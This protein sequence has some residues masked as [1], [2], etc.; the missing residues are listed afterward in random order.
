MTTIH[1]FN[2]E[3]AGRIARAV[4]TVERQG[5]G[6]IIRR[7]KFDAGADEMPL[8]VRRIY[9]FG[10]GGG[11]FGTL[12]FTVNVASVFYWSHSNAEGYQ[13]VVATIDKTGTLDGTVQCGGAA[14]KFRGLYCIAARWVGTPDTYTAT[15]G[16]GTEENS[17]DAV[18]ASTGF[19]GG[20]DR[21]RLSYTVAPLIAIINCETG[22][23]TQLYRGHVFMRDDPAPGVVAM[24]MGAL[25]DVPLGWSVV[26]DISGKFLL[27]TTANDAGA[28]STG[29]ATHTH[30]IPTTSAFVEGGASELAVLDGNTTGSTEALPPSVKVLLI[31]KL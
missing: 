8:D 22:A 17:A 31:R 13:Q 30:T 4:R 5:G 10:T 3:S 1:S 20:W 29:S 27:A 26:A 28:T 14:G 7:G 12:Y 21:Q 25:A 6:G 19:G 9:P 24:W 15:L 11:G 23:V 16:F 18:L 2:A